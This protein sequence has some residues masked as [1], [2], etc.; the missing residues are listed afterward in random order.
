M[1]KEQETKCLNYVKDTPFNQQLD[2]MLKMLSQSLNQLVA[3]TLLDI[4]YTKD[5]I[6][7]VFAM[8]HNVVGFPDSFFMVAM[9]NVTIEL[10]C[11]Y[12][13]PVLPCLFS[14][15]LEDQVKLT[16]FQVS[17]DLLK[18][19]Q[20]FL[21]FEMDIWF[22]RPILPFLQK[23]IGDLLCSSHQNYPEG[24]NIGVYSAKA[25]NATLEYFQH[26]LD[27]TKT[28]QIHDQLLIQKLQYASSWQKAGS[29]GA[30]PFPNVTFQHDVHFE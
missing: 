21:F 25:N 11:H 8:A 27:V 12:G 6:H 29:Q 1:S 2:N 18:R 16:K 10:C 24:M 5:M 3:F 30:P 15:G 28:Y 23:Q 7:N 17:R 20:D 26:C 22:I 14:S 19:R 4:G 9:D 13:Y